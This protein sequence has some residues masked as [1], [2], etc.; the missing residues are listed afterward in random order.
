MSKTKPPADDDDGWLDPPPPLHDPVSPKAKKSLLS[1][2]Y[3]NAA[4]SL[5]R[6]KP[7]EA[8]EPGEAI[9][10]EEDIDPFAPASGTWFTRHASRQLDKNLWKSIFRG[11][12]FRIDTVP[13]DNVPN[14]DKEEARLKRIYTIVWSETLI[15]VGLSLL[16]VFILPFGNPVYVYYARMENQ[17]LTDARQNRMIPLYM[18]NLTNRAV[19]S[20]AATS[21]SEIMTFGFGDYEI[22]LKQQRSRFTEPGWAGF[23]KTFV[24]KEIGEKFQQRQL[25]VTTAPADTPVIVSQGENKEHIYEW[26]VQAPVIVTFATNN[27]ITSSTRAIVDLTIVRVPHEHN[28]SGIAINIWRQRQG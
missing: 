4:P 28:A 24:E 22:K 11:G 16:F 13:F 6:Q 25:V 19:L 8:K 5:N 23:V 21:I 18:P 26:R 10:Q 15:I 27:N 14:E 7:D 9:E 12:L 1:S 17:P 3:A 2:F 20:W